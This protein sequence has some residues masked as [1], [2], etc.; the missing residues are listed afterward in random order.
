MKKVT[1]FEQNVYVRNFIFGVEDSLVST[2]GLV[3]GV[4]ITLESKSIVIL[5][6]FVLIAV[7]AFSMG[8]GSFLTEQAVSEKNNSKKKNSIEIT[9][10]IIMFASYLIAGLIPLS[11]YMLFGH[12][13]AFLLSN[14][15]STLALFLLGLFSGRLL[16]INPLKNGF[17][18]MFLG[19]LVIALGM[20]VGKVVDGLT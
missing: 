14:L 18:M 17:K 2:V 15:F 9:G 13:E 12:T 11:P 19:G 5:T 7:E 1:R 20:V 6:G 8:V 3:S 16:N 4:A 10:S